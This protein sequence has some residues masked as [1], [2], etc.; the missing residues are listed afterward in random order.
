M[1][2]PQ[3]ES[4]SGNCVCDE[5]IILIPIQR[6]HT[7]SIQQQAI[8][9]CGAIVPLNIC[10]P[11]VLENGLVRNRFRQC[12]IRVAVSERPANLSIN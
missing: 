1:T 7:G 12:G 3:K 4:L 5:P 2:S 8:R 9:A 11:P 10:A 6:I